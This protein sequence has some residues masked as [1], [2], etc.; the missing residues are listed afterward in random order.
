MRADGTCRHPVEHFEAV[1]RPVLLPVPETHC[2]AVSVVALAQYGNA[3][4]PMQAVVEA[5]NDHGGRA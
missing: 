5:R 3:E 4:D 2:D 1:E